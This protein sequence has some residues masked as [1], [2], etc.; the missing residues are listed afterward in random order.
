MNHPQTSLEPPAPAPFKE[1]LRSLDFF[2]G[3]TIFLLIGEST[4]LYERLRDPALAGTLLHAIGTQLEH[5][6]WAVL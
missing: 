5:H 3:L 6:P 1:R 4:H 2:R